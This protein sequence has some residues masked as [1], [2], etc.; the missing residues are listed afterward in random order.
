MYRYFKNPS[1]ALK[2]MEDDMHVLTDTRGWSNCT[3]QFIYC[4]KKYLIVLLLSFFLRGV[5]IKEKRRQW[6]AQ[7][8]SVLV[9][10][11]NA[12]VDGDRLFFFLKRRHHKYY[13]LIFYRWEHLRSIMQW[14]QES[15]WFSSYYI[16]DN[17]KNMY[18][19]YKII[20]YIFLAS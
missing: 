6:Y 13:R 3:Y 15:L 2:L 12:N 18:I 14:L 7:L 9:A 20:I 16:L 4:L 19:I 8:P 17:L 10:N 1:V 5:F 11:V